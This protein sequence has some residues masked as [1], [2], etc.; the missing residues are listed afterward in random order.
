MLAE[1]IEKIDELLQKISGR[2]PL[3]LGEKR[4]L[5]KSLLV[6]FTYN[7]NAI[8][9]NTL[10]RSETKIILEDGLTV[11]GKTIREL[12]EARNHNKC[13]SYLE[14]FLKEKREI[15]EQVI[16]D[17][18]YLV[19][20]NIDEEHAGKYRTVQVFISGDTGLPPKASDLPQEM[21]AFFEWYNE[22]KNV[23][24]P[25][26]LAAQFHYK[27]VKI[28]PFI[29]GNGRLVRLCVNLILMSK[30]YLMVIIPMV[31]R[32]EYISALNSSAK[33]E[34]FEWFFADITLVN[35]QDY[36]RMIEE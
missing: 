32:A 2:R 31:R 35:M 13:F 6:E 7:S 29:D 10:T 21:S 14:K 5:Q 26:D 4:E 15:D 25:V 16:L 19:L 30:G 20:Q 9:G 36:W 22:S 3:L 23:L 11:G 18:H 27:L 1:K 12:D 28:H 33:R 8:E 17:L 34:V 24:H